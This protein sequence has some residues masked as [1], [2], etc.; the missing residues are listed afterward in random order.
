MF[1]QVK[2]AI[3]AVAILLSGCANIS[4]APDVA[5]TGIDG[6]HCVGNLPANVDGL[7]PVE[8]NVLLA[9]AQYQSGKGGVCSAR[10]FSVVAPVN[11]YRV[12][13]AANPKS[14]FGGW[15]AMTQPAGPRDDYRAKNAICPEWSKLDR[16]VACKVKVGAEIVLGTTQS[17]TCGDG[18]VYPKTAEIQVFVP[19]D[20]RNGVLYVEDCEEKGNW[21]GL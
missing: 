18:T 3:Y 16:L 5:A 1:R 2:Y 21:P 4:R 14:A 13:D 7:H 6:E 20:Q 11:V 10:S 19:N 8:N 15:W 12:Y 9:K 17:V